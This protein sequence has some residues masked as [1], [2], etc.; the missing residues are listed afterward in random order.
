MDDDAEAEP[1]IEPSIDLL[2]AAGMCAQVHPSREEALAVARRLRA[3]GWM[4][5]LYDAPVGPRSDGTWVV[6]VLH[7]PANFNRIGEVRYRADTK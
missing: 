6:A 2:D 4:V 7:H 1:A 3:A 5:P